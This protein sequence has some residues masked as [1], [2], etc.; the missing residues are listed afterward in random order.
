MSTDSSEDRLALWGCQAQ[1]LSHPPSSRGLLPPQHGWMGSQMEA[2][3][4]QPRPTG[5]GR[6]GVDVTPSRQRAGVTSE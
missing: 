4:S 1:L 3:I 6:H 5:G 2:A